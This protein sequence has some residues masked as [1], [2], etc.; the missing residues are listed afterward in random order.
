[1]NLGLYAMRYLVLKTGKIKKIGSEMVFLSGVL[2]A[3]TK[4]IAS[5][6]PIVFGRITIGSTKK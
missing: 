4:K 3:L 2:I 6:I 5:A 1:M